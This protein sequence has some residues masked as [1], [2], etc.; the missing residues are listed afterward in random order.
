LAHLHGANAQAVNVVGENSP[1]V[2]ALL[3]Q[4]V[5]RAH[6]QRGRDPSTSAPLG[7]SRGSFDAGSISEAIANCSIAR[8]DQKQS[9][10]GTRMHTVLA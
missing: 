1:F 9:P 8:A 5:A 6:K 2:F 4:R 3:P 10:T 7:R